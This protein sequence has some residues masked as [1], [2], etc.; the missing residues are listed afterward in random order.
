MVE[1]LLR[2]YEQGFSYSY[3]APSDK[4]VFFKVYGTYRKYQVTKVKNGSIIDSGYIYEPTG[5]YTNYREYNIGTTFDQS[6][7]YEKYERCTLAQVSDKYQVVDNQIRTEADFVLKN[8]AEDFWS[9]NSIG[10]GEEIYVKFKTPTS[11][12]YEIK[13]QVGQTNIYD[14]VFIYEVDPYNEN[15]IKVITNCDKFTGT[16]GNKGKEYSFIRL[17][18]KANTKYMLKI[19]GITIGSN[20]SNRYKRI[21]FVRLR[22]TVSNAL[23]PLTGICVNSI[24][25][26]VNY[27][28]RISSPE[29]KPCMICGS[30]T[31]WP[32][33]PVPY[34]VVSPWLNTTANIYDQNF[35]FQKNIN[36][37]GA[38]ASMSIVEGYTYSIVVN[39]SLPDKIIRLIFY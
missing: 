36:L 3:T 2:A 39:G 10:D 37:N 1:H 33:T 15:R 34:K 6:L 21:Y 32:L 20:E 28:F 23:T 12:Y 35:N 30:Q 19:G 27:D 5:A 8:P 4:R 14:R 7:L 25:T 18:L 13:A 9:T 31:G 24:K 11:G 26:G 29:S 22:D 16:V 38:G 17:N